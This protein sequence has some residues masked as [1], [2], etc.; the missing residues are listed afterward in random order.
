MAE[1]HRRRR[2][3]SDIMRRYAA[4]LEML[5]EELGEALRAEGPSW[6]LKECCVEA[7][8]NVSVAPDEVVITADMPNTDPDTINVEQTNRDAL[9]IRA[10]MKRK[11]R[12]QELGITHRDGEFRFFRCQTH[13]PVPVDMKRMK[14]TFKRGILTIHLPR[15]KGARTK[16]H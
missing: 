10:E 14:T 12:F 9:E 11:V 6:D 13:V 1:P 3:I 4:D 5:S 7:L 2:S 16:V 8:C 15:T